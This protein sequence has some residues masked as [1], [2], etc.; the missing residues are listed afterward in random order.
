MEEKKTKTTKKASTRVWGVP[1][2]WIVIYGALCGA[3]ML[4][5]T[6]P[7]VGGGGFLPLGSLLGAMAP[8]IMGPAGIV[9]AFIGGVIGM[10]IS[11]A[12]FP[13]GLVDVILTGTLPAVFVTLTLN[14][15]K[16]WYLTIPTILGLGIVIEVFTPLYILATSPPQ[17]WFTFMALWYFLPWLAIMAS[18]LGLKY[19]ADWIR[20]ED[21]TKRFAGLFIAYISGLG[22]WL[23]PWFLPY[24]YL[25]SYPGALGFSVLI[26]Y[27]WWF[28]AISIV[29]TLI[30]L[31]I[32]EGLS[33]SGLP[34]V[35][36]AIWSQEE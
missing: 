23:I 3:T 19:L 22:P 11:P 12:A 28:V 30:T 29:L 34:P 8:A 35:P 13:L 33:K 7:Y 5:P 18:P 9:A 25:F 26:G 31:P 24:W 32:V 15:R 10:F 4:I 2:A 14:D 20:G 16:F 6:F 27:S 1:I 36:L 21:R 17:P